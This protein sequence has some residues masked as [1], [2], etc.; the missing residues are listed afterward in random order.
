MLTDAHKEEGKAIAT[1]LS[2]QHNTGGEGF[3]LQFVTGDE[4]WIHHLQPKS[5][6]Q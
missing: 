4:T 3:L 2:H 6:R 1:D 5:K